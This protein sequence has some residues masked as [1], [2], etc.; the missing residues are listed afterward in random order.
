MLPPER[1]AELLHG[2]GVTDPQVRLQVYPHVL[3]S[4]CD[5]VEWTKGTSLTRFFSV[6]PAELHEPFLDAYR[7][8]LLARVGDRAP[9]LYTFKRILMWGRVTPA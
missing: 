4:T 9:Y 8:E 2:L 1:Y 3:G 6:L 7:A 5:V